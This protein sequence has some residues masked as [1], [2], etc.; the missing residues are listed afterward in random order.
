[1][2]RSRSCCRGR[3]PEGG[4]GRAR[5]SWGALGDRFVRALKSRS[6]T[7][8]YAQLKTSLDFASRVRLGRLASPRLLTSLALLALFLPPP[9]R[10]GLTLFFFPSLPRI[11]LLPSAPESLASCWCFTCDSLAL[12]LSL[13]VPNKCVPA[14]EL[15]DPCFSSLLT[16]PSPLAHLQLLYLRQVHVPALALYELV[17]LGRQVEQVSDDFDEL[18]AG[19]DRRD[20]EEEDVGEAERGAAGVDE[21]VHCDVAAE[22][23]GRYGITRR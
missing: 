1:M 12:F 8:Y 2:R 18:V 11:V 15:D 7:D 16:P 13:Y 5:V 4:G 23:G 21:E 17:S 9:S 6:R 14:Y 3:N 19:D 20:A 10:K 22:L